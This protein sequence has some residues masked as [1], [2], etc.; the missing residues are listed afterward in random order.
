MKTTSSL[1]IVVAVLAMSSTAFGDDTPNTPTTAAPPAATASAG[2]PGRGLTVALSGA[3]SPV[4]FATGKSVLL[5]A[6]E[7][8]L[9]EIAKVLKEDRRP[10]TIIGHA[11]ARGTQEVNERLSEERAAAVKTFLVGQGIRESRIRTIGLGEREPV[12]DNMSPV[13]RALN[14]RVEIVLENATPG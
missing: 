11:D 5:P 1:P 9:R 10:L 6:A 13:G 12:A 8:H 3:G 2:Q 14:R 4:L 7:G